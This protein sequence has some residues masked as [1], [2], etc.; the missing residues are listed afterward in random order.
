MNRLL[1]AVAAVAM[2]MAVGA[3]KADESQG[4][5]QEI[6][7]AKMV[8]TLEDGTTFQLTEEVDN[9]KELHVGQEVSVSYE[10]KSGR[11]FADKVDV[12]N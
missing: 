2:T 12:K 6:D 5:I 9:I 1:A 4:K 8:L 11:K 10:T 3:A 7:Q